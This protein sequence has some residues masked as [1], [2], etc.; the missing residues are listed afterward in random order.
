MQ[1]LQGYTTQNNKWELLQDKELVKHDL[2]MEIYTNKGECDWNPTLGSTI[3]DQVFQYKNEATKGLI[4]DELRYIVE[5]N[6]FLTLQ[7]IFVEDMDKGWIFSLYVSYMGG[8]P[9]EW[10]VPLNEEVAK[11]YFSN[12]SMPIL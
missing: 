10:I 12:G 8:V 6:P 3:I 4:M 1:I 5:K 7:D 9:E 11:E 2:M